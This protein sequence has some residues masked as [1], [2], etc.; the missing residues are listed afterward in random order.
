MPNQKHHNNSRQSPEYY[1]QVL[2]ILVDANADAKTYPQMAEMLNAQNIKTPTN[3]VWTGEHI[4]QLMK[5]LRNYKLYPSFI[6]QHLME[7]IFEGTLTVKETLPLFKSRL[8]GT[9]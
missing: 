2:R 7:L 1:S 8:H 6:H 3:L 9:K 5:K 4:K